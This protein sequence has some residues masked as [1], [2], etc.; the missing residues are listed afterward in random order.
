MPIID[1][2]N[3]YYPPAYWF[4]PGG[5]TAGRLEEAY[6]RVV[7]RDHVAFVEGALHSARPARFPWFLH[8]VKVR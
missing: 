2:H 8:C 3:H 6:R 4:A 5:Q 1:F 7:L